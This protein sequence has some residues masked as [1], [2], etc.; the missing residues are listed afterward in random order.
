MKAELL[1]SKALRE[2]VYRSELPGGLTAFVIPKA[3]FAH[4]FAI[5]GTLYGSLDN[6]FIPPGQ[7]QSISMP[8]GVPHFM[9]HQLFKK[10]F[11]DIS[12]QFSRLGA[13]SNA[14]T[15]HDMTAYMFST[16]SNFR[17]C[18]ELIFELVFDMH[19]SDQAISLER[20]IIEQE[21]RMYHDM[22]EWTIHSNMM[23]ALYHEHPLRID[24]AGT[25]ESVRG[26]TRNELET[27][28]RTFYHPDN[29]FLAIA[30]AD[31]PDQCL[32][33]AE[34]LLLTRHPTPTCGKITR[35]LPDEPAGVAQRR[36]E[37]RM[38][39]SRPRVIIG[40]KDDHTGLEGKPLLRRQMLTSILLDAFLGRGSPL[41]NELYE[42]GIIDDSFDAHYVGHRRF[43]HTL[44][45]GETDR[46]DE[47]V[48]ELLKALDSLR[49][50][51]VAPEDFERIR[52][53]LA[54]KIM[55]SFDSAES[56]AFMFVSAYANDAQVF[57]FPE[58]LQSL[59]HGELIPL[60]ESHLREERMA[61]SMI[62]P[63][64]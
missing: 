33:L 41:Y 2:K 13:T 4:K 27:C 7:F 14:L 31:R 39:V 19:F 35:L 54:G 58:V 61:V 53:K 16:T 15:S 51:G 9:E 3:G 60:V 12:Q 47:L 48:E 46:P 11:G 26:I 40:F 64:A 34:D 49:R 38:E 50:R 29:M 21:I 24:I 32:K 57:D 25:L 22:P 59:D 37:Q 8:A 42:K 18:L 44:M 20:A 30:G 28:Y 17:T 63:Q 36:I 5:L 43:A 62:L 45:G 56:C 10:A 55:K 1:E 6:H 52:R 23:R